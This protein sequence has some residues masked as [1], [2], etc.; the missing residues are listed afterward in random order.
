MSYDLHLFRLVILYRLI[1]FFFSS[2]RRHT[3]F[4]CDWSS[5]VCSSDLDRQRGGQMTLHARLGDAGQ[6][7]HPIREQAG[8]PEHAPPGLEA[9]PPGPRRRREPAA[10]G[11]PPLPPPEQPPAAGRPRP[12][13]PPRGASPPPP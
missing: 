12:P 10:A 5:D 4:K 8:G 6:P 13:H 7:A 11:A 1:F 3:R 2:R 9:E